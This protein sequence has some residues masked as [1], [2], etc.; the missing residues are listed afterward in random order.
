MKS[1]VEPIRGSDLERLRRILGLPVDDMRWL[2]GLTISRWS[3]YVHYI[4]DEPVPPAV[5]LLARFYF[6]YPEKC[7]IPQWPTAHELYAR[8]NGTLKELAIILGRESV[9]G[10][11][12]VKIKGEMS[13]IVKRLA[14]HLCNEIDE[15]RLPDWRRR[16]EAE[17]LARGRSNIWHDGTWSSKEER[18][19][20]RDR[21]AERKAERKKLR[22]RDKA[23]D[24]DDEDDEDGDKA[25]GVVPAAK[26]SGTQADTGARASSDA[27]ARNSASDTYET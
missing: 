6:E 15:G 9:S 1:S 2:M 3:E 19:R 12:W 5:A 26:T 13:P 4:P 21:L 14:Y 10:F 16:V 7:P 17:A 18:Q 23:S 27:A 24:A 8:L 20:L 22:L 11:R 25:V